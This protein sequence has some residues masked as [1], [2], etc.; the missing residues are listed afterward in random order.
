MH[1]LWNPA[2]R[3]ALLRRFEALSP[4]AKARWGR[5][6]CDQMLEHMVDGMGLG[7]GRFQTRVRKTVARFWP[8]NVLFV[9]VLPWPKGAPGPRE[10]LKDG[11]TKRDW[12]TNLRE[13]RQTYD[14]FAQRDRKSN[15]W[16]AHPLFGKL[17]GRAWGRLGWR[18]SDHH[19]RQF[20][21]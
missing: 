10:I 15:D 12:Q 7:L 9:Y 13:L 4:D 1:T 11:A 3:A 5:M 17:S 16:P 21:G 18:H 2:D 14:E 8:V 6:R 20:G 19:L